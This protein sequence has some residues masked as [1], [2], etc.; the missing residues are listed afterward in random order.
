M[1][2]GGALIIQ[3]LQSGVNQ[4]VG[5]IFTITVFGLLLFLLERILPFNKAWLQGEDW[6]L[7]FI[8]YVVNYIIK[9]V[10]QFGFI[11]LSHYLVLLEW[12]P[13]HW[14]FWLQVVL[15]LVIIDFCLFFVHWQSHKYNWLW[16]LH[17]VHH[18]S[19][20]LYFLNGEKR[21]AV[22]QILEGGPGIIICLIIGT[23]QLVVVA[24]LGILALNMMMQHTNLDY[25]SGVLKKLFCVA[26]LH[27]WHHREDYQK[28]QVNFGAWLTL[29]DYIFRSYYDSKSYEKIGAIG[30]KDE[31][32]FPK[33]YLHQFAYPFK[34][35]K[36]AFTKSALCLLFLF[37][38]HPLYSQKSTQVLGAWI[39][40]NKDR[41]VEVYETD[42]NS[43]NAR[44]INSKVKGEIGR[45]IIHG[46]VFNERK[47]QYE[48]GRLQLPEMNH[49]V[50]CMIIMDGNNKIEVFGYHFWKALGTSEIYNRIDTVIIRDKRID[51]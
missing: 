39:S 35:R 24:A 32:D 28:S 50:D 13:Q 18:S 9:I 38:M 48:N 17:A 1:T 36:R 45:V 22:H 21:H 3:L 51:Y 11:W 7:D 43:I 26:E 12:F 4:Y 23:P 46:L 16:K 6:N 30:I 10:A 25:R 8:Y 2:L 27:R 31:A 29:W 15:V 33:S 19:E 20:R 37:S 40:Q 14:P 34:K 42:K 5:V 49:E 47:K 44:I 41:T